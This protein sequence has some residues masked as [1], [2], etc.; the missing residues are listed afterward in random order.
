MNRDST[1]S[2]GVRNVKKIHYS[3]EVVKLSLQLRGGLM[4]ASTMAHE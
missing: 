4:F 1:N 2:T 3:A